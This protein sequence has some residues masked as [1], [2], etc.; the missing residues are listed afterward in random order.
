MRAGVVQWM[1]RWRGA[2]ALSVVLSIAA[3]AGV[4]GYRHLATGPTQSATTLQLARGLRLAHQPGI[5]YPLLADTSH[6]DLYAAP[7]HRN[8]IDVTEG[9]GNRRNE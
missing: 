8:V 9:V 5:T 1:S 4:V 7:R 6:A 3:V 2:L